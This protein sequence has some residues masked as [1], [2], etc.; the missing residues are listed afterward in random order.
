VIIVFFDTQFGIDLSVDS[1]PF[2]LHTLLGILLF[3]LTLALVASTDRLLMFLGTT[4]SWGR[5]TNKVSAPLRPSGAEPLSVTW[6]LF[7]PVALAYGVLMVFQ[8]GDYGIGES[9][10]DGDLVPV[11]REAF[12]DADDMPSDPDVLQELGKLADLRGD[13]TRA[14]EEYRTAA[15]ICGSATLTMVLSSTAMN[16]PIAVTM[17]ACHL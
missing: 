13:R 7:V 6:G 15:R 5:P 2:Y 4:V 10:L 14:I 11:A 8:A 3:A 1:F 17:A 9:I 16:R 12:L